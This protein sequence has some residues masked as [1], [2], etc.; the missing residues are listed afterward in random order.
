[1]GRSLKVLRCHRGQKSLL[2]ATAAAC[3]LTPL[4]GQKI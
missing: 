1:L 4:I 3:D 2:I